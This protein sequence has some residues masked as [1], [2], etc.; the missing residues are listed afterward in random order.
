[1][2]YTSVCPKCHASDIVCVP[3]GIGAYGSGN[4]ILYG[5]FFKGVP[6]SRYVCLQ[7]GF[8]EEWIDSPQDLAK[9]RQRYRPTSAA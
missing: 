8:V 5:G 9:L 6:V 3:G 7:C 2:K 1:M 4:N